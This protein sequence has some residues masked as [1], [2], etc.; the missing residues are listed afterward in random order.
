M[1]KKQGVFDEAS[2]SCHAVGKRASVSAD[3][4]PY[5]QSKCQNVHP[6]PS[7]A[8]S[9]RRLDRPAHLRSLR[10]QPQHFHSRAA[11]VPGRGIGGSSA[12]QATTAVSPS[13][14]WGTGG[15]SHCHSLQSGAYRPRPLDRTLVG[16]QSRRIGT[17]PVSISPET[18]RQLLKKMNSNPGS[19]SSGASQP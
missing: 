19:T 6:R 5:R 11:V 8:Q 13:P 17:T 2:S 3:V 12:R 4:H 7:P 10:H 18:I 9:C 14:H 15:P 1:M 16:G